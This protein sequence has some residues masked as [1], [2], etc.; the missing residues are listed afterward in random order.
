[1]FKTLL[2]DTG[3]S[4]LVE[5]GTISFNQ[6]LDFDMV[7]LSVSDAYLGGPYGMGINADDAVPLLQDIVNIVGE[8]LAFSPRVSEYVL[9]FDTTY[10]NINPN[11]FNWHAAD[12]NNNNLIQADDAVDI[13]SHIVAAKDDIP[14]SIDSFDL[15]DSLT[16]QRVTS[17]NFEATETANWTIVANGDVTQDGVWDDIYTVAVE[18]V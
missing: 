13:L 12:V 18:I 11:S 16:Y 1:M 9:D 4:T 10:Y 15:I 5:N 3:V 8:G 7:K 2:I 14:F 17:L 6:I